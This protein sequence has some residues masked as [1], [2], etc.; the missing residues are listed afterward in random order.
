M[1]LHHVYIILSFI[2]WFAVGIATIYRSIMM[3]KQITPCDILI[4]LLILFIAP[5][6]VVIETWIRFYPY[7]RQLVQDNLD[8]PII[9]WGDK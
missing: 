2:L 7:M 1:T 4:Y 5:I 6:G 9:R 3:E 8:K